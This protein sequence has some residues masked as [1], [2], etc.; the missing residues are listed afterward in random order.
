MS[1]GNF[2]C[3]GYTVGLHESLVENSGE[4]TS[5]CTIASVLTFS[6]SFQNSANFENDNVSECDFSRISVQCAGFITD[7]EHIHVSVTQFVYSVYHWFI[8]KLVGLPKLLNT[9]V[10]QFLRQHVNKM[11]SPHTHTNTHTLLHALGASHNK[12][13]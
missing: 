1:F 3:S 5:S 2:Q 10:Q 7:K 12:L 9:T 11:T 13:C 8:I 6:L 4:Y